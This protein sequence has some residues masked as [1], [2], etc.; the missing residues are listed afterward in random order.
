[1]VFTD[2]TLYL[3][4]ALMALLKILLVSFIFCGMCLLAM[5]GLDPDC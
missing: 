2:V 3:K 1:M 5:G 4:G